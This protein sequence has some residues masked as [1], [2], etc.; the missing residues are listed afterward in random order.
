MQVKKDSD[1]PPKFYTEYVNAVHS[2]IEKNAE[3]EFEAIWR[4]NKR[5]G[6]PRSTISDDLSYAIVKLNEN[7]QST[8]L[9]SNVLLR[10]CILMEALPK[11]LLETVVGGLE[12]LLQRI[13][14]AYM[15]AIFGS[16][17]ASRFIYHYGLES[18]QFA[19]F[20]FMSR[21]FDKLNHMMIMA[22]TTGSNRHGLSH[23]GTSFLQPSNGTLPSISYL[24]SQRDSSHNS[25]VHGS[26]GITRNESLPAELSVHSH[27]PG[28]EK[29]TL[30]AQK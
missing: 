27:A 18:N 8:S 26:I 19:F 13:P 7:L 14:E 16:Y 1:G 5:T 25:P 20:E 22:A 12:V 3:L 17:L 6:A 28:E 21:Y 23:H 24:K 2:I 4:E 15:K 29:K 9:W 11:I 10:K 30:V